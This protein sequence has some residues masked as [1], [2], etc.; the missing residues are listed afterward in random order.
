MRSYRNMQSRVEG[1]QWKKAHLYQGLELM[2]RDEFYNYLED[3]D[4]KQLFQEYEDSGYERKLAPSPDRVDSS[5][6]YTK[7]NI[8][9]VTHSMNSRRGAESRWGLV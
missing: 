7:E 5:V 2:P 3:E 4:F 1:V 9:W 8:E 6:G